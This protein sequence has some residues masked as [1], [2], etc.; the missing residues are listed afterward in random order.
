MAPLTLEL[1]VGHLAICRI[2]PGEGIPGWARGAGLY[3]I[4]CTADEVSVVCDEADV[5]GDVRSEPGW[6]AL[7]VRGPL[8]F[9]LTGILASIAAPLAD[10]GVSIFAVSTFDTDYVLIREEAL[11]RAMGALAAAGH[12]VYRP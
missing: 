1:L 7:K 12:T 4:T 5:P 9:A 10:A 2:A 8:D 11:E 3:S 6:R